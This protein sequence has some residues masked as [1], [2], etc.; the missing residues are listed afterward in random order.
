MLHSKVMV[1]DGRLVAVGSM[2]LDLRS[3]LQN[4][5]IALLIRSRAL[6]AEAAQQIEAAMREASWHLQR[7]DSGTLVWRAPEGSGLADA[8]TDPDASLGL[9]LLLRLLGPLAPDHLL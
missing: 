8:Y 9:R 4:T 6:A 7:T 3:Q 5:E 2:N 1:M